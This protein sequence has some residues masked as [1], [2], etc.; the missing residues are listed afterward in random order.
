MEQLIAIFL[1]S[2]RLLEDSP[3]GDVAMTTQHTCNKQ[4]FYS[5]HITY[6]Q[7]QDLY[8]KYKNKI[9]TSKTAYDKVLFFGTYDI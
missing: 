4:L 7:H 6:I 8:F 2:E 5:V 3:C 1:S 9:C